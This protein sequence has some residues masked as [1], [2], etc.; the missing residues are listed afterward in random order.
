M[1][2]TKTHLAFP[3]GVVYDFRTDCFDGPEG[4]YETLVEYPYSLVFTTSHSCNLRCE[5]CFRKEAKMPP[6][7][8]DEIFTYLRRLPN[9]K[10]LR[11]VLSGASHSG[12]MTST[13]S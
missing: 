5:Y 3:N 2:S 1:E 12:V 13:R 4:I 6:P 10:P 7:S 8:S 11:I 9:N